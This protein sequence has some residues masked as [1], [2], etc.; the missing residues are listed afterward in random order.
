[1]AIKPNTR[2]CFTLPASEWRDV[3]GFLEGAAYECKSP[4]L[5]QSM[6]GLA[7]QLREQYARADASPQSTTS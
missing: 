5:S 7:A 6:R 1:M 2:L 4:T 3:I